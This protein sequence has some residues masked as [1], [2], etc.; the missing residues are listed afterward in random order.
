[1]D[2]IFGQVDPYFVPI[3]FVGFGYVASAATV[4]NNRLIPFLETQYDSSRIGRIVVTFVQVLTHILS[5]FAVV[6]TPIVLWKRFPS[7]VS[8]WHLLIGIAAGIVTGVLYGRK[9]APKLDRR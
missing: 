9:I 6:L 3:L 8:E 4:F 5:I 1:M 7:V 2:F